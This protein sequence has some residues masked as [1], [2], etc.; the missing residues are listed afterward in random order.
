M[1]KI[2]IAEDEKRSRNFIVNILQS[3]LVD[4]EI[5]ADFSD[6]N[7]V[8]EY[9]KSNSADVVLCD[10]KMTE[11]SGLDVAKWIYHNIPRSKV[12]L[13]SAYQ[14]FKFATTAIKYNVFEYLTKPVHIPELLEVFSNLKSI[15]DSESR[16]SDIINYYKVD[17][18]NKILKGYY[19]SENDINE[20]FHKIQ[21]SSL[22]HCPCGTLDINIKDFDCNDSLITLQLHNIATFADKTNKIFYTSCT[23]NSFS[24]IFFMLSSDVLPNTFCQNIVKNISDILKKRISIKAI[25]SFNNIYEMNRSIL[26]DAST[27]NPNEFAKEKV[28]LML[29]S[30]DISQVDNLIAII[31]NTYNKHTLDEQKSAYFSILSNISELLSNEFAHPINLSDMKEEFNDASD[32]TS[33]NTLLKNKFLEIISLHLDEDIC[34]RNILKIRDYIVENCT[35]PLTLEHIAKMAHYSP[36][37][38]SK[39]FKT[40]I[41]QTYIEFLISC[42]INKAKQLLI[43]TN[44]KVE[45]IGEAVGYPNTHSFMRTFKK[46][47][48]LSPSGYRRKYKTN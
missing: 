45:D 48:N 15:L 18:F 2:I 7:E 39:M 5:V 22:L 10:I 47:C 30:G 28:L 37:W 16:D 17:I 31:S 43:D 27:E 4:F 36:A 20:V 26:S 32:I 41:G 14:D 35:Q 8:I 42:R 23:N 29:D 46:R 19:T 34:S 44:L 25:K 6:G 3:R 13:L 9:L 40:Y 1:Y 12:I 11:V 24:F 33:L 21:L 38:F